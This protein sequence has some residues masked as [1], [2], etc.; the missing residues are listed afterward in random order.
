MTD[1]IERAKEAL[2]E[3]EASWDENGKYLVGKETTAL[4]DMAPDLARA[5]IAAGNL[6]HHAVAAH[7]EL[8]LWF[9]CANYLEK[10]G[11]DMG[12]TE[13]AMNALNRALVAFRAAIEGAADD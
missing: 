7:D 4:E 1:L 13:R 3:H 6:E 2:E 5:L 8:A 9:E 12:D 10:H 11:Y